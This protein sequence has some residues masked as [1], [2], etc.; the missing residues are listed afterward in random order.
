MP[1]ELA[2]YIIEYGYLA[3]FGL[4]F[5]QEI[6]IPNPVPNEIVLI[7]SGYLAW[8]GTLSFPLIFLTVV[9]ADFLGTSLLYTVFYFFG[10][11]ILEKKPDWIP[12]SHERIR[13]LS[14]KISKEDRWGLYL[15]R[16]IPYVRGYVSV[17]AG[18]LEIKPVVFLTTVFL[19]AA[20]WSGG[21]V[22]LG[23]ILGPYWKNA[24]DKIGG[25]H[26][27]VIIIAIVVIFILVR[28]HFIK[29]YLAKKSKS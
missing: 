6:G 29:P 14:E 28:K 12:I 4:V 16:L 2:R 10:E 23:R 8:D 24:I 13:K 19:S 7:F 25:F 11:F 5:L 26:N 3:I 9:M 21:Y 15:G 22:I 17:A 1:E 27:V 18:L 20:T